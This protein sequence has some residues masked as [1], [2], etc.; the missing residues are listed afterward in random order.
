MKIQ[1]VFKI[2][3]SLFVLLLFLQCT[4]TNTPSSQEVFKMEN[5]KINQLEYK[6]FPYT[7]SN[8]YPLDNYYPQDTTGVIM[9]HFEGNYY[10]HPVQL[11]Q[12][13]ILFIDG[14][15]ITDNPTY[16][17]RAELQAN[18]LVEIAINYKDAIY[19]PYTFNFPLHGNKNETMYAPWYSGMAQG[20]SLSA[21]LRLYTFTG[22]PEYMEI[23]NN[24]FNSF[25]YFRGE[26]D[27][28][29]STIDGAEYLWFEE[30]PVEPI[31]THALNGF[32]FAIYGLY[33]YYMQTRSN[34]CKQLLFGGLTT[35]KK[36]V[37]Q[38]RNEG[39]LSYYCLAH[40]VQSE[41]YHRVHI[42]Q[43]EMLYKMTGDEY[44]E[45][46]RELLYQDFH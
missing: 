2:V 24:I 7:N 46:M 11:A 27:Q 21:F 40:K 9:F 28:W 45:S 4:K 34:E 43:M 16:I 39:E 30:Y 15:T 1:L 18:K 3:C 31:Q 44:F 12:R 23:A 26:I 37:E 6:E 38:Y 29:F 5:F 10:Y 33:E 17:E 42:D 14:Y 19:F 35:V 22:K 32:I 36:Y 41:S 25:K 20:Q 13:T 8:A